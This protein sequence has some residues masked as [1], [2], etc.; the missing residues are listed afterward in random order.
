MEHQILSFPGISV[1]IWPFSTYPKKE[2]SAQEKL[3]CRKTLVVEV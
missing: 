3:E 1:L 2:D